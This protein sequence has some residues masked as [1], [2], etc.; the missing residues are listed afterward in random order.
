MN[1]ARVVTYPA[2]A[3]EFS[4]ASKTVALATVTLVVGLLAVTFPLT[5][6]GAATPASR[7][8]FGVEPAS[9]SGP[10]G[11][12]NFSFGVT[13]GAYLTDHVV[14]VSYSSRPV[15]LQLYPADAVETPSGGFGLLLQSQ[16]STGVGA[17]ITLAPGDATVTVPAQTASAPGEVV[18]PF[19]VRVPDAATPGDHVG[20]IVASLRTVGTNTS[21]QRV[22][23]NQRV[24]SR[25]F[26][27]V[28]G[29]LV[30]G[31]RVS[32][33]TESYDGTINPFGRGA[34]RLR[35]DLT[36]VGNVDLAVDQS[37]SVAGLVADSRHVAL[38]T[39]PLVLAGSSIRESVIVPG[40]WPQFI[41]TAKVSARGTMTPNSTVSVSTS[42]STWTWAVPWP[43]IVL[44]IVVLAAWYFGRRV[45]QHRSAT[46]AAELAA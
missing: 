26:I 6:A 8:S 32:H 11:R 18:V 19:S 7:V 46:P 16:K 33:L 42:A 31:L 2:T 14:V 5:R 9:A 4:A 3:R 29:A 45:R 24:G 38:P 1:T 43:L 10:D 40:V 20:G 25:V 35:Y 21:G 13:P 37:V 44:I 39:D 17:W 36:N 41:A 30:P 15:T 12:A 28:S 22:I 34:L 23:L 27:L